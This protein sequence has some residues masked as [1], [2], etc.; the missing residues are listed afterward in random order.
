MHNPIFQAMNMG[1]TTPMGGNMMQALQQF[2][3]TI[4]GDP[5]QIVRG[6]LN[7]GQ[8]SQAQFNQYAQ[9]AQRFMGGNK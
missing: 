3:R 6:M 8:M 5:E 9:M 4:K 2:A 1:R 7:S